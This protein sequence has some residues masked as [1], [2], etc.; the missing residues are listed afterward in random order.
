MSFGPRRK[1]RFPV[2]P[3][4]CVMN[5]LP[6]NGFSCYSIQVKKEEANLLPEIIANSA[7]VSAVW[8]S[9]HVLELQSLRI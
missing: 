3:L 5:L 9:L 2:S 1:Q 7:E 4:T 8:T 6:S